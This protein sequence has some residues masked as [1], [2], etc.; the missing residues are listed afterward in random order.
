MKNGQLE[1]VHGG[2]SSTDEAST[3]YSDIL[4]NFEQGS[5][6][7]L[8]EFGVKPRIG[9]QL[10][11]FGHSSANAKLFKMMGLESIVFARINEDHKM[12]LKETQD[13][14]FIW[15]PYFET[16]DKTWEGSGSNN[17]N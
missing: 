15:K 8:K 12:I 1:I 4:R 6:F 3:S 17:N 14:Q 7:L 10:D 16:G 2:I 11:P 9:W 13:M 5:D